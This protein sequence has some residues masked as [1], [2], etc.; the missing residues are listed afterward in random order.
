MS[1]KSGRYRR[2][3]AQGRLKDSLENGCLEKEVVYKE[4]LLQDRQRPSSESGCI[5]N[6]DVASK[7]DF[8]FGREKLFVKQVCFSEWGIRKKVGHREEDLLRTFFFKN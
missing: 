8:W 4:E 1:E 6:R 3:C 7:E 5:F 2:V